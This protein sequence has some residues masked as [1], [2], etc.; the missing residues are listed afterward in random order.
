MIELKEISI[1]PIFETVKDCQV[2]TVTF[3]EP[4]VCDENTTVEVKYTVK[5]SSWSYGQRK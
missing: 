2:V 4:I 5:E 1:G 3:K